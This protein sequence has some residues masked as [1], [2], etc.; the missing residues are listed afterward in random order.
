MDTE[1]SFVDSDADAYS[2]ASDE[3]TKASNAHG[4]TVKKR[5]VGPV[6]SLKSLGLKDEDLTHENPRQGPESINQSY[7]DVT[8]MESRIFAA[9][10]HRGV[11]H[12]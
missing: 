3:E 12:A 2:S 8:S 6:D 5:S 4:K 11:G 9:H 7:Q 1:G 10:S